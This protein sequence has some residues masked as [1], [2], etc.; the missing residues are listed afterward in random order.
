MDS[1]KIG[2][3]IC[4]LRKE[5]NLTQ[6]EL[7][8][9]LYVSDKAVSKWERGLGYPD[10]SLL[11]EL[12][13]IFQIPVESIM[14]GEI[15]R[16]E[17]MGDAM[18][19]IRFYTCP[20]CGSVLTSTGE[21]EISC[22][23]RKLED[24]KAV[25]AEENDRLKVEII[26]NEYYISSSHEMKKDHFVSFIAFVNGDTVIIRKLYPEWD[27]KTRLPKLSRGVLYWYC[28]RHGFF[29]QYLK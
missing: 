20:Q 28:S 26:D 21:G 5:K 23:G 22:C 27:L 12:S 1:R 6:R 24:L 14:S 9:L 2:E 4:K 19:N 8:D 3:L 10:I 29:Y 13:R 17:R 16:A 18:K 15:D 25:K 11:T 7:G